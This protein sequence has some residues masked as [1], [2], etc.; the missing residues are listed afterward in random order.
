MTRRFTDF[1]FETHSDE[2]VTGS[3]KEC[4]LKHRPRD[5]GLMPSG[6]IRL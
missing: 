1:R 4:A 6:R 3:S 5:T 2:V